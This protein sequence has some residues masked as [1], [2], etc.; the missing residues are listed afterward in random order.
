MADLMEKNIDELASLESLD[1]G[2]PI[3]M[4]MRDINM[5][6]DI[7]RYFAGWT[8]KIMGQTIP[9]SGPYL[10]Y[11]REEPIGVCA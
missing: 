3:P 4:S 10:C 1:N 8:D 7:F 2:K 11:T 5:S 9:I 6:I